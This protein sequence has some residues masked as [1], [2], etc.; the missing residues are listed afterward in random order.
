MIQL[1]LLRGAF[2]SNTLTTITLGIAGIPQAPK[3]AHLDPGQ[4]R[5]LG[6]MD[7]HELRRQPGARRHVL[8]QNLRPL[9]IATLTVQ[10]FGPRQMPLQMFSSKK[11]SISSL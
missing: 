1:L 10:A 4:A 3:L 5:L 9:P 6:G 11:V 2:G 8:E 7:L